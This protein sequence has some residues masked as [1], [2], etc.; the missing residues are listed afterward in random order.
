MRQI[1]A[2]RLVESKQTIPHYQVTMDFDMDPLIEMRKTLNQQLED[3]DADAANK[4]LGLIRI[5]L[6]N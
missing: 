6:T 4:T 2:K 5:Y 1:I 3:F